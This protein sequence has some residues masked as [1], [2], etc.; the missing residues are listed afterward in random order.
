MKR[1]FTLIELLVTSAIIMIMLGIT[2]SYSQ[3]GEGINKVNRAMERLAFDIRRVANLSTQ[4]QEIGDKKICGWGIYVDNN[5]NEKYIIF[6]DFC[7]EGKIYGNKKFDADK[8]ELAESINLTKNV[9]ISDSDFEILLYLPP[10]PRLE[11]YNEFEDLI[12]NGNITL[13]FSPGSFSRTVNI[14]QLGMITNK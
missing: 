4:T 11:I 8:N 14:N 12:G 3:R 7:E 10:E 2:I 13:K 5:N 6:S 9:I 1:G